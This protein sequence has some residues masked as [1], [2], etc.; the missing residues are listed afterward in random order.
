MIPAPHRDAP[1]SATDAVSSASSSALLTTASAESLETSE[2]TE[3]DSSSSVAVL[4][5]WCRLIET[6]FEATPQLGLQ[7]YIVGRFNA[8]NGLQAKL[9]VDGEYQ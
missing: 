1:A 6:V 5:K 7:T 2:K 8:L 3:K 4:G 9:S